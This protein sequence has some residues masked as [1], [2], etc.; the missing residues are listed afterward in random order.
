MTSNFMKSLLRQYG[1]RTEDEF[2]K[3]KVECDGGN[4]MKYY[5]ADDEN[6]DCI[7]CDHCCDDYNCSDLCGPEHG[8]YGYMRTEYLEAR[9]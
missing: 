1:R 5:T 6:P 7:R 3:E 4:K 8:W 2:K 9:Q